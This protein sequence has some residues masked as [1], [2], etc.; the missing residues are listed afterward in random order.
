V[1]EYWNPA[2]CIMES[3]SNF[4]I[5]DA[6]L[7]AIPVVHLDPN[8]DLLELP[9]AFTVSNA[10]AAIA[11]L[12]FRELRTTACRH[13]AFI[14]WTSR[15]GWSSRRQRVFS[16]LVRQAGHDCHVMT[17]PWTVGNRAEVT[18]RLRS[19]LAALPR[20]CGIFAANDT[21]AETVIDCCRLEGIDIPGELFLV[22]VDDDPAVCDKLSPTLSSI[23]P[24]FAGGGRLAARLLAKRIANPNL[25][26][27]KL[28]YVPLGLTA[29]LS[30]RRIALT[31]HRI[32]AALDLIRRE[33]CSGLKAADVVVTMGVTERLAETRFK[34][35]TNKRITEEITDVRFEHVLE[36]LAKPNQSITPIATLCGWD[37]DIYLK[38]LFKKRTG[39]S[40]RDWRRRHLA[41]TESLP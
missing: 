35:A 20:P 17:D 28:E 25:P 10:D 6:K 2:G 21:F 33:A 14:G 12:A 32:A 29:R 4:K 11:K 3:S 38:R 31:G 15:V 41:K 24:N 30:S 9:G 19:F 39:L 1:I 18:A 22:G 5:A 13:F 36:L 8:D 40:M 26:A 16:A 37:S 7:R 34:Q 23:R 27:E